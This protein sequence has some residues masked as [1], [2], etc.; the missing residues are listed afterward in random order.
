M[1]SLIPPTVLENWRGATSGAAI[2]A[3]AAAGMSGEETAAGG[4]SS[5][6]HVRE[7][8][9]TITKERWEEQRQLLSGA[10][11]G[12]AAAAGVEGMAR[13]EGKTVVAAGGVTVGAAGAM[14]EEFLRDY[15]SDVSI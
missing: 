11:Y 4:C 15:F 9:S 5:A 8:C 14:N 3:V 6:S 2:A 13:V 7:Q 12:A 1:V 10:E